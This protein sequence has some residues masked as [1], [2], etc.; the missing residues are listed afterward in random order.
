MP[1]F[2]DTHTHAPQH[3]NLGN[4][5]DIRLLEWLEKYTFPAETKFKDT[6]Y[7]SKGE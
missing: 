2:V 4:G 3:V 6:E 7:A 1:G 5:L